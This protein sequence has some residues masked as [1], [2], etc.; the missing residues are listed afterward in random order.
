MAE[1]ENRNLI[2]SLGSSKISFL[3][4]LTGGL[5]L[6]IGPFLVFL[7]ILGFLLG[8]GSKWLL[9][10]F[11]KQLLCQTHVFVSI[12]WCQLDH[13]SLKRYQPQSHVGERGH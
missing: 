3:L 13:M 12:S 8:M 6:E 7:P 4:S 9:R 11:L 10:K 2:A 5:F 1:L